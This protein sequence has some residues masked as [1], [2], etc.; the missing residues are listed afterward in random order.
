MNAGRAFSNVQTVHADGIHFAVTDTR[1]AQTE[2]MK[3][4]ARTM[5]AGRDFSNVQTVHAE[6]I[7]L[8]VTDARTAQTEKMKGTARVSSHSHLVFSA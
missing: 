3:G 8:A 4:T 7:H 2:K 1:T 6:G 5:N